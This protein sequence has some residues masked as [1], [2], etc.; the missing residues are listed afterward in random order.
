MYMKQ[1]ENVVYISAAVLNMLS[2]DAKIPV[3]F[4]YTDQTAEFLVDVDDLMKV[5]A[6]LN[7]EYGPLV[8]HRLN[9]L[10]GKEVLFKREDD[11]KN[12]RG[13]FTMYVKDVNGSFTK[14]F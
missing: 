13:Y 12:C 4:L 8:K 2:Q 7:E 11:Y 1:D 5:H 9:K 14:P 6:A 10:K 3:N